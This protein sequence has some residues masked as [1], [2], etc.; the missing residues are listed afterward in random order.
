MKVQE[1]NLEIEHRSG[2]SNVNADAL[3]RNPAPTDSE[4]LSPTTGSENRSSTQDGT[5]EEKADVEKCHD[6]GAL[7]RKDPQL[8][9]LISFL[10]KGELPNDHKLAKRI[11]V[12]HSQNNLID[13]LHHEN[14][15][16]PGCWRQV[17]PSALRA[18]L[19]HESHGLESF[20]DISQR[21]RCMT[22]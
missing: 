8:S 15:I 13:V 22:P 17:V 18:E 10:E 9:S 2:K 12:E 20:L 11:A 21:K 19:L 6:T 4:N 7:Q 3:S 16:N 14:P 5:D 1:M